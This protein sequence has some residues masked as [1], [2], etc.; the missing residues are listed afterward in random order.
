MGCW[1]W[2]SLLALCQLLE[3]VL[4]R[5]R[6]LQD[7]PRLQWMWYWIICCGR[8]SLK[9]KC[10]DNIFQCHQLFLCCH[11][12]LLLP[13]LFWL[14]FSPSQSL[15]RLSFLNSVNVTCELF[16]STKQRTIIMNFFSWTPSPGTLPLT[17]KNTLS[18]S[19]SKSVTLTCMPPTSTRHLLV[20]A[21]A[22]P[23]PSSVIAPIPSWC[24]LALTFT[25][26]P[27]ESSWLMNIAALSVV[28]LCSTFCVP[29]WT[30]SKL[31]F[32]CTTLFFGLCL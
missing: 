14:S 31:I 26:V 11:M 27:T 15:R 21:R 10:R 7:S 25:I 16:I 17:L 1:E 28:S 8:Y 12:L 23:M 24:C 5:P 32:Y 19:T 18:V 6:L 9:G 20:A 29:W 13:L 22:A 4:G 3:R 30:P 2:C